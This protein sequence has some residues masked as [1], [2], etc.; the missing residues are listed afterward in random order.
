MRKLSIAPPIK[1]RASCAFT[2]IELLV[3]IV[4]IGILASIALVGYSGYQNRAKAKQYETE[5]LAIQKKAETA[6]SEGL[7]DT[8]YP[9]P[10]SFGGVP[11]PDGNS[12][13]A[14][15]AGTGVIYTSSNATVT[16]TSTEFSGTV[17]EVDLDK[18]AAL[19]IETTTKKR[20]YTVKSCPVDKGGA[21]VYGAG[22]IIFYPDPTNSSTANS[23]VKSLRS[24]NT[25][26]C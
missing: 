18:T 19:T 17:P 9:Y 8:A 6:Y 3:V 5:A 12:S 2:I 7:G 10:D 11:F 23:A 25:A 24:G 16:N 22:F 21:T 13:K 1:Q 26:N 15:P 20:F 14:L 4:V